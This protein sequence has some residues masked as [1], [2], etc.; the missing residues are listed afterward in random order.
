MDQAQVS[1]GAARRSGA[2]SSV[3]KMVKRQ[4][5]M[6]EPDNYHDYSTQILNH[7]IGDGLSEAG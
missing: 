5:A 4:R 3:A 7:R 2:A 1:T 6:A